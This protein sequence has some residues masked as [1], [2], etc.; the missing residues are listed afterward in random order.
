ML[1]GR[2]RQT[3]ALDLARS[4]SSQCLGLKHLR[5]AT[6]APTPPRTFQRWRSGVQLSAVGRDVAVIIYCES[7]LGVGF[8]VH[9]V[10]IGG[11]GR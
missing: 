11:W 7:R 2:A 6:P 10:T 4:C 3:R 9:R 5:F 8:L 1:R